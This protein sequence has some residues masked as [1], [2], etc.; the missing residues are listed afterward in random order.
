MDYATPWIVFPEFANLLRISMKIY[1][2]RQGR[3]IKNKNGRTGT[4]TAL[5]GYP[6]GK[7]YE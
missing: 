5:M 1:W 2:R 4:E 6:H 3:S 7:A